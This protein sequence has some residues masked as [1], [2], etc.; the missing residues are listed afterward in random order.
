MVLRLLVLQI[1]LTRK[2]SS[3]ITKFF[4][5]DMELCKLKSLS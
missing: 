2:Q 3:N 5:I 1:N 4:T